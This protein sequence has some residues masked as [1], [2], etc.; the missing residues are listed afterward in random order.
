MAN[1]KRPKVSDKSAT[2]GV[3]TDELV[4]LLDAADAHSPRLAALVSVLVFTG[5]RISE[6]LGVDVDDFRHDH[7]H[8]VLRIRRKGGKVESVVLPPVTVRALDAAI[9]GRTSGPVFLN[10]ESA[11]RYPYRSAFSQLR[12][13][14][15]VAGVGSADLF[16]PHTFRHAFAT[17]A[18]AS[19]VPLQDVQDAL[20]HADPRTTRRYDRSRLNLDRSPAYALAQALRRGST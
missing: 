12:R 1:V 14:A 16:K 9:D 3:S 11:E 6:A 19:G 15:H 8:R 2:A 5:S 20:G 7:G 17:E 10:R 4:R 18:L 13:L